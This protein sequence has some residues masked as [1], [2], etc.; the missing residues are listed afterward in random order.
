VPIVGAGGWPWRRL[1]RYTAGSVI[2]FGVAELTFVLLFGPHLLG[3]RGASVVA[4]IAGI[5]PGYSLNRRWTWGRRG[6]SDIWREVVP[7]WATAL[8]STLVA[9]AVTGAVN[10]AFAEYARQTRTILDALAYMATYG[11]LFVAKFV[12]FDR[13]LFASRPTHGRATRPVAD[14]VGEVH[15]TDLYLP[16]P[17]D[18]VT[19]G[20]DPA[21][22]GG[23][24]E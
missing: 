5:I 23:T 2:C 10:G 20:G 16:S 7:Y 18:Y 8:V 1:S 15:A 19:G 13:L 3:A 9:A 11:A 12:F 21:F 17:G 6:K 24:S 4:S 22:R 14:E